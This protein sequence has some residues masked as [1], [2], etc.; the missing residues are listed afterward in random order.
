MSSYI[1]TANLAKLKFMIRRFLLYGLIGWIAEIIFTGLSSLLEGS[2]R[3]TGYTYLWMFPI[4][5][6]A[7]F[8]EPIH[9][10]IRQSPWPVRGTIWAGAIFTIEYV[11]GWLLSVTIGVCPWDYSGLT[12]YSV[13][14]FIRLDFFPVWFIAGLI[15]ERIHDYLDT[16][17]RELG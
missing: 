7:V 6:M 3:L 9:D 1:K 11:T 14:G 10:R 4:Y 12:R 5:G 13:D 16:I 15:F 8:L 17:R 2:I